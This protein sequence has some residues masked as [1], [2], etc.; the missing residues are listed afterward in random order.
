MNT[1]PHVN[2][3][4]EHFDHTAFL[5]YISIVIGIIQ[6]EAIKTVVE[7]FYISFQILII[8]MSVVIFKDFTWPKISEI[9]SK[10][11]ERELRIKFRSLEFNPL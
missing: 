9:F 7:I 5:A 6:K 11:G 10:P 4:L 8:S 2:L 1:M 3:L